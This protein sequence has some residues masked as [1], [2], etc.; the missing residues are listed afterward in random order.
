MGFLDFFRPRQKKED[1]VVYYN[2]GMEAYRARDYDRALPLLERAAGMGYAQAQYTCGMMYYFGNGTE[3]QYDKALLW[4]AKAAQQGHLDAQF[5]LAFMY[6]NGQGTRMDKALALQWYE[7]AAEQGHVKSQFNC[8]AIY[9]SGEGTAADRAKAKMWF[10]RAAEQGYEQ[11]RAVLESWKRQEPAQEEAEDSSAG[12]FAPPLNSPIPDASPREVCER[13]LN[14]FRAKHYDQ[15]FSLL[16]EVCPLEGEDPDLNPQGHVALGWLYENRRTTEE[17][18]RIALR[19]YTIAARKGNQEGM[20]GVVRLSS[21]LDGLSVEECQLALRYLKR[22]DEE[23]RDLLQPRLEKKLEDATNLHRDEA[24]EL[25]REGISAF[26]EEN[27]GDALPLLERSA[28]LGHLNAQYVCARM[29]KDGIGAP[30]DLTRAMEYFDAAARQGLAPAQFEAGLGYLL[31]R[32]TQRDPDLGFTY[33]EQAADQGYEE[34]RA[35]LER[36]SQGGDASGG[37]EPAALSGPERMRRAQEAYQQQDWP[38]ALSLFE[39]AAGEGD[40]DAQMFCG[41]MYTQGQGTRIDREKGLEWM[42]EAANQ[43]VAEAQVFCGVAYFNGTGTDADPDTAR[44]WFQTAAD[45]GNEK[46]RELLEKYY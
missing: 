8:G 15:A 1:P 45:Q 28:G 39:E 30:E 44:V 5:N 16:A 2:E 24:Q 14:L 7:N 43:G 4:Y 29:Y 3:V 20:K 35:F 23:I 46:A 37:E 31:G 42:L 11:A 13:G 22:Q 9:A 33:M 6:S 40:P 10:E 36:L 34:A 25:Y 41:I 19:H 26:Q 21:V 38:L 27:Y 12:Q 32:G 17:D 18:K